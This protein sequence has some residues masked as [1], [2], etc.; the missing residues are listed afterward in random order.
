MKKLK[1][2]LKY[3]SITIVVIAAAITFI[4][5]RFL[6]RNDAPMISGEVEYGV[7]YKNELKAD[8][9]LPTKVVFDK[10]PVLLYLHGGAW[11]RGSKTAINFN[12]FNGAVNTLREKGYT[13]V[14]ADYSL[15]GKTKQVF[16]E[17]IY[18]V[19]D[20]IEWIKDNSSKYNL[21]TTNLGLLGES[22][23]AHIAMMAA[24]PAKTLQPEK[25][26][27]TDFNYLIDVYGPNDLTDVYHGKA[28]ETIDATLRKVSKI[29]GSEF[30]IK[31]YVF[32]FDP[33]KDSVRTNELLQKFSPI[34]IIA[35][36]KIPV[37]IIH[38]NADQ[39][40]PVKQSITLQQKMDDLKIPNE[41]HVLDSVDHNF[42]K[43]NQSQLDSVQ[44]WISDFAVSHYKNR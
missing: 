3:S 10:S 23:G 24:F 37:L 8:L 9:Y 7:P 16:P 17:S 29:F 38:G 32:G 27:K 20:A 18:D 6:Y 19:Y 13:I 36:D 35:E 42:R 2:F 40:V 33:S 14:A 28:L 39:I 31:E 25:Y 5:V 22:A 1:S 43:A 21:D 41:L 4:I 26:K 12:R 44:V 30:N 34:N 11:I 15:A